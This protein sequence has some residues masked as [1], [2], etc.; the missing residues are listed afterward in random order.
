MDT[1]ALGI[2][3]KAPRPGASKTRL[4]SVVGAERAA[5]LS[6]C[7]LRD[8]AA[9]IELVPGQFRARGYGV[10]APAGAEREVRALLPDSFGLTLQADADLGVVLCNAVRQ[11]LD[12][13]HGYAILV[14]A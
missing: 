13:G 7:F 1:A 8:V 11:L 10:Y 5:A 4:A 6:A 2:M 12:A 3:C 9:S 14:N